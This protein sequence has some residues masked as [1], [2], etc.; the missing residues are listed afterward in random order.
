MLLKTLL[1]KAIDYVEAH[2]I[3]TGSLI[4]KVEASL[5]GLSPEQFINRLDVRNLGTLRAVV[6][7]AFPKKLR[8]GPIEARKNIHGAWRIDPK[9][10]A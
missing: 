10:A 4:I 1:Q 8:T 7:Q 5:A 9:E 2:P 3:D 6:P